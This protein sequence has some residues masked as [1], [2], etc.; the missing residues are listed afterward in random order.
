MQVYTLFIT[1]ICPGQTRSIRTEW[2]THVILT[3]IKIY[4]DYSAA[5]F[6]LLQERSAQQY[7]M[8]AQRE[9]GE[10][11][12]KDKKN[13]DSVQSVWSIIFVVPSPTPSCNYER[14]HDAHLLSYLVFLVYEKIKSITLK[15]TVVE[16]FRSPSFGQTVSPWARA[17]R[18]MLLLILLTILIA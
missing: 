13:I 7:T 9:M 12:V 11:S 14:A 5:S 4:E 18:K 2:C 15:V 10:D 1:P 8:A 16:R 3:V 6:Y 17:F